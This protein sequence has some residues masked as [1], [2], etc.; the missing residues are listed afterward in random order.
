MSWVT[1]VLVLCHFGECMT[2]DELIGKVL[3]GP[4]AVINE[5]LS[6]KNLG[7]MARLDPMTLGGGKAFQAVVA[8]GAFN[9]LP[10]DEFLTMAFAQTW[11]QPDSVQILIRDEDDVRFSLH[12]PPA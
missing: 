1:N 3:P 7:E 5:W 9:Y 11:E 2:H 12:V 6:S 4:F 10:I 8:G